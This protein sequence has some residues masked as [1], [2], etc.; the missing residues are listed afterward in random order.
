MNVIQG[1]KTVVM[2]CNRCM[3]EYKTLAWYHGE[4]LYNNSLLCRECFK[5]V[6]NN[7]SE[8]QKLEWSFY[9]QK[10]ETINAI[11]VN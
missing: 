7:L 1:G 6:F 10:K 4:G 2:I 11:Q 8:Q 5:F 3:K 9:K